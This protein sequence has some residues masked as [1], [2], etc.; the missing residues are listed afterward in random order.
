MP[1]IIAQNHLFHCVISFV[2]E[3]VEVEEFLGRMF[4]TRQKKIDPDV[5]LFCLEKENCRRTTMLRSIGSKEVIDR[6]TSVPCDVC[7]SVPASLSFESARRTS[8]RQT[9]RTAVRDVDDELKADLK[10]K[11]FKERE[12][13]IQKHPCYKMVGADF[14]CSSV[15]IDDIC[16]DARFIN[17]VDSISTYYDIHPEMQ[18]IFFTVIMDALSNAPPKRKRRKG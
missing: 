17:S 18:S 10:E 5:K 16:A 11:L 3:L 4:F 13:Y 12:L 1:L 14:V 9:K 7:D 8:E 15:V 2:A 6:S